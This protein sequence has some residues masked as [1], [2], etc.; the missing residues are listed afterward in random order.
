MSIKKGILYVVATPIGN[1][2]DLSQRA[3]AV[4]RE[5]TLI[6]AEDTRHSRIL[7]THFAITTP[8]QALHEHNERQI[9]DSLI[10]RLQ[11]GTCIALISDAGTPLISD[12]GLQ[13]V[14][15]AHSA[16]IRV[17][18]IPGPSALIS[19]LSVAGLPTD[20][21]VFEGFLPSKSSARQQRLH[22]L[23]TETR[24]LVFFEAPHRL[25]D[26][27]E[28]MITIFGAQRI[29]TLAKELTKLFETVYQDTLENIRDWLIAELTRQKGEFVLVI[30]GAPL[31]D[32]QCINAEAERI[33]QLLRQELPQ[34]QAARLASQITGVSQNALYKLGLPH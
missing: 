4:L 5:V 14:K 20:R 11:M 12:P 6:V 21:F 13:L 24:T 9:A 25:L 1:L 27:I 19:A 29:A 28:D 2:Q 32:K 31:L 16:H 26:C 30:Q 23:A 3:Q 33:F 22:D 15:L 18:P 8:L 10:Q 17:V 7:L 34:K